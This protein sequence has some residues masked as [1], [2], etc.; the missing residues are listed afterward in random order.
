ME[1]DAV[2]LDSF[3][4]ER[5]GAGERDRVVSGAKVV[6]AIVRDGESDIRHEAVYLSGDKIGALNDEGEVRGK[7][8]RGQQPA[9]MVRPPRH[10]SAVVSGRDD[11]KQMAVIRA[12]I[13][14]HRDELADIAVRHDGPVR[15]EERVHVVLEEEHAII[16]GPHVELGVVLSAVTAII[17]PGAR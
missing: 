6:S 15:I 4:G 13:R 12:G 11:V 10:V 8:L 17:I 2:D 16:F 7:R 3:D 14:R 5:R 1:P 9:K